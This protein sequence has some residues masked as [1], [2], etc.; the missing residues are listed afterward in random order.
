M[1]KEIADIKFS[2]PNNEIVSNVTAQPSK[3]PDKIKSLLIEQIEKPVRWRK[4]L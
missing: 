2:A 3:D 4:A 1:K